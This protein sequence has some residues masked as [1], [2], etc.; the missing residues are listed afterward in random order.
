M[1]LVQTQK[2]TFPICMYRLGKGYHLD[3]R[4]DCKETRTSINKKKSK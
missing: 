3:V 1:L 2:T 4:L